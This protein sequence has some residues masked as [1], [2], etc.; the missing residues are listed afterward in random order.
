MH[1]EYITHESQ[2]YV[3]SFPD[4]HSGQFTDHAKPLPDPVRWSKIF[5]TFIIIII[6]FFRYMK[7]KEPI[8]F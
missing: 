1:S 7:G 8:I 2:L 3:M 5:Y 6:S 4:W